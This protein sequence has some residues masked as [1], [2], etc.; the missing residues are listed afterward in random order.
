LIRVLGLISLLLL[1]LNLGSNEEPKS[2]ECSDLGRNSVVA[3][4]I[5]EY[6]NRDRVKV[7]CN[8]LVEELDIDFD[9]IPVIGETY[10]VTV[11]GGQIV[12]LEDQPGVPILEEIKVLREV[13]CMKLEEG[14]YLCNGRVLR[15]TY[16]PNNLEEVTYYEDG[17]VASWR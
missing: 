9:L 1:G 11:E 14:R 3:L 15:A 5:L 17:E 6:V 10:L 8:G 2:G 7:Y 4:Q 16:L 13:E 12:D